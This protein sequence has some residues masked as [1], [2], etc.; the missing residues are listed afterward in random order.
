[1]LSVLLSLWSRH[2][3]F[4]CSVHSPHVICTKVI[5]SVVDS[6]FNLTAVP[7]TL[8]MENGGGAVLL[9]PV[10]RSSRQNRTPIWSAVSWIVKTRQNTWNLKYFTFQSFVDQYGWEIRPK[11]PQNWNQQLRKPYIQYRQYTH[12]K[13]IGSYPLLKLWG[14]GVTDFH[15]ILRIFIS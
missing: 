5:Y 4:H 9:I 3:G 2:G 12:M 13:F 6:R 10:F 8:C 15:L 1:M 7:T 14:L 11:R